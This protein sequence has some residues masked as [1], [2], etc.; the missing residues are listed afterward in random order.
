MRPCQVD[1]TGVAILLEALG[2]AQQTFRAERPHLDITLAIA[3]APD[4]LQTAVLPATPLF[5]FRAF[6]SSPLPLRYF[7]VMSVSSVVGSIAF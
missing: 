1:Q 4:K 3:N 6:R 5:A 7:A 2:D